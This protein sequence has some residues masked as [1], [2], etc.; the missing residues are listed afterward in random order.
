[1]LQVLAAALL[2]LTTACA[3]QVVTE[4]VVQV[5]T[6][7]QTVEVTRE[8]TRLVEVPVTIT[9]SPTPEISLTPTLSPTRTLVPTITRTPTVTFTPD[10]PHITILVNTA[11]FFGPSTAYLYNYAL[12]ATIWME[13]LG[14]APS[15]P[16]TD[17][18]DVWLYIQGVHGWNPCWV[19][20]EYVRFNDGRS[21]EQ[22]TELPIVS[23]GQ[24]P[25][26]YLYRPPTDVHTFR[27]GT[28]VSIVWS[29][30][31]MTEDDYRGY[32]VEA[33]LCRD[34]QLTFTPL[35]YFPPIQDNVGAMGFK[36][37]DEPGCFLPS[38]ARLYAVEK[39]GY[40]TFTVIDWP[41]YLP[42]VTATPTP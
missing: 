9:P 23:Q 16:D 39:H 11:C 6:V 19:K 13:V 36:V 34:G 10:P 21:L 40:T 15:N 20:S 18:E 25:I 26:S 28:E 30:I 1:M 17:P 42:V 5:E 12:P 27:D 33:W 37:R 35:K 8:V 7:E 4:T 2:A 3:P 31:W 41:P 29:A 22:H 32:M 38:S 14:R 24:L